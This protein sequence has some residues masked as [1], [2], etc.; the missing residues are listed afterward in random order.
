MQLIIDKKTFSELGKPYIMSE[1]EYNGIDQFLMKSH[2]IDVLFVIQVMCDG[3]TT[4]CFGSYEED[5][6]SIG[7][8][9]ENT[10]KI[11]LIP[12]NKGLKLIYDD[13]VSSCS[14]YGISEKNGKAINELFNKYGINSVEL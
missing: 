12:L 1:D 8:H 11:F 14:F 7:Y 3:I 4:D 10:E 6:D 9:I 5:D 13:F 2:M